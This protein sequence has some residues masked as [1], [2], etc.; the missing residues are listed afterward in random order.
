VKLSFKGNV[1]NS[2]AKKF[3][4]RHGVAEINPAFEQAP[5]QGAAALMT[6][7]YCLL[8]ELGFCKKN[9]LS[10]PL[11]EPLFLENNGYRLRLKFDCKNCEM[12]VEK[13][14]EVLIT[15][16]SATFR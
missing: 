8:R 15:E 4:E 5:P 2:Y 9:K 12:T 3:Y 10:K 16:A 6:T 7:R 14:D 13:G 11:Q 1:L